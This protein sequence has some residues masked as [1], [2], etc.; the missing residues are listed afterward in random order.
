VGFFSSTQCRGTVSDVADCCRIFQVVKGFEGRNRS[1]LTIV[2]GDILEVCRFNIST[3][4]AQLLLLL[5]VVFSSPRQ[6]LTVLL[7]MARPAAGA[8]VP[9]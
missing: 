8:W 3:Q 7:L 2:P 9:G 6:P 1:E 5:V 4:L